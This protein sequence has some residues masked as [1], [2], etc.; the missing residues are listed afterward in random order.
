MTIKS[1][2]YAAATAPL[3]LVQPVTGNLDKPG[4]YLDWGPVQ[5]S[6]GNL[7]IIGI[8]LLL[9]LLALVIPFPKGR[10]RL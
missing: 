2:V 8:G 4:R 3:L 7:V 5:I 10:K 1:S 9:F 6:L